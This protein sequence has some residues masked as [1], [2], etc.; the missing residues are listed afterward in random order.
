M[1][2]ETAS[3]HRRVNVSTEAI[4][5]LATSLCLAKSERAYLFGMTARHGWHSGA[6][7]RAELPQS[8]RGLSDGVRVSAYVMARYREMRTGSPC[9]A[10]A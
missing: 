1:K 2:P 4:D 10:I 7:D 3:F 6:G 8:K 5:W 9:D